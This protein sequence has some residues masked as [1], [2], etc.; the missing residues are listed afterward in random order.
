[1]QV[2]YK[3]PDKQREA[4]RKASQR[5]RD[6]GMTQGMTNEGMTAVNEQTHVIPSS[7]R[8]KDIKCFAD[9]PLDVQQT[10]DS[11]S[12]VDGKIDK[13]IKANRTVIAL[14][15]QQT[16]GAGAYYPHGA[17]CTGV[18]TGKPGNDNY[19]GICTDE[20]RVEHGR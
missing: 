13:T 17:T 5:K 15:Y 9:L 10:I 8:G 16:F 20:W 3:D 14:D 19:D 18:V 2:M 12:T 7:K 6:K 11:M 1:M 4:N